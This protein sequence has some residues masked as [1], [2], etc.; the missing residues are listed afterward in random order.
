MTSPVPDGSSSVLLLIKGGRLA[1]TRNDTPPLTLDKDTEG[2]VCAFI[3]SRL[4]NERLMM[5]QRQ[6]FLKFLLSSL[7]ASV[8]VFI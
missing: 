4:V 5:S 7:T 3:C 2:C 8:C 1:L 6:F